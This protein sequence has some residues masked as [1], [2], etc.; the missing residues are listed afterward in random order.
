[1]LKSARET[2]L[3]KIKREFI[4]IYTR[5][6]S[7]LSSLCDPRC[8]TFF[9]VWKLHIYIVLCTL[10]SSLCL[11]ACAC[12]FGGKLVVLN[13]WSSMNVYVS[14]GH[15]TNLSTIIRGVQSNIWKHF[16]DGEG[17]LGLIRSRPLGGWIYPEYPDHNDLD[18]SLSVVFVK[19]PAALITVANICIKNSDFHNN[20]FGIF[21][22]NPTVAF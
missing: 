14:S 4:F 1:M 20:V 21:H 8:E 6:F 3:L 16:M 9:P 7:L 10:F 18:L 15:P 12:Y 11:P 5:S 13:N 2:H 19:A 22:M 17:I